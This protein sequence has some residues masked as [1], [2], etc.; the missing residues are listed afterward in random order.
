[1]TRK[2]LERL[3]TL[4]KFNVIVD[5]ATEQAILSGMITVTDVLKEYGQSCCDWVVIDT[6]LPDEYTQDEQ[7]FYSKYIA[8]IISIG[9]ERN[10]IIDSAEDK[11]N[12]TIQIK[13]K[14]IW[15]EFQSSV[16]WID[17]WYSYYLSLGRI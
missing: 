8:N 10:V 1:M 14:D 7:E 11:D 4:K 16:G 5:D 15:N 6:K 2:N 13:H 12:I 17:N 9:K 3:N